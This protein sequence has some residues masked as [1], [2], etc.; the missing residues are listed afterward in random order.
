MRKPNHMVQRQCGSY[1]PKYI[2]RF[3]A[4]SRMTNVFFIPRPSPHQQ[5]PS[6]SRVDTGL[7]HCIGLAWKQI[8]V[9]FCH[10]DRQRV[11]VGAPMAN[12]QWQ[13]MMEWS[14]S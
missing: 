14:Q 11:W 9:A 4:I 8:D 2:P 10:V 1:Q 5:L 7:P 13:R 6:P 12:F 3:Q